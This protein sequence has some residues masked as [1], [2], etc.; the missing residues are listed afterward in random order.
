M[1]KVDPRVIRTRKLIEGAF[2]ELL[3]S[4]GFQKITV[5]DITQTA[6]INR[7]TFYAHFVDKYDLY[8][9]YIRDH[10]MAFLKEH[11]SCDAPLTRQNFKHLL[12]TTIYYIMKIRPQATLSTEDIDPYV[13]AG[14]QRVVFEQILKW[15]QP[16]YKTNGCEAGAEVVAT[17][18]SWAIFGVGL[19]ASQQKQST[20]S[21]DSV[22]TELVT[23]LTQGLWDSLATYQPNLT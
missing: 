2:Q 5:S 15:I 13:E 23:V 1:E 21:V 11:F 3:I 17:A 6:A 20:I 12:N 18:I 19:R 14:I 8:N 16:D 22:S 9:H 7:A 4:K 10:F